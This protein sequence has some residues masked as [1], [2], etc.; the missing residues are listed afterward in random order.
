[1]ENDESLH[2]VLDF[3]EG[4]PKER[5]ARGEV[6]IPEGPGTGRMYILVE[7]AL[8]VL[9]GEETVAATD[10]PGAIFGEMSVLL[11]TGHSA[12]VRAATDVTVYR[13]DDARAFL[14][15][16]PEI[17]FHVAVILARR[18][19]DST[20]YLADFKRQFGHRND[21]FALVDQVLETLVQRQSRRKKGGSALKTD[22]RL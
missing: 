16:R 7:G 12:S 14:K 2:A 10:E 11:G 20:I 4:L 17:G 21:H 13:I 6:L 18:L 5:H 19:Q 3:C 15:Q 1:M 9:R 22:S 8:E